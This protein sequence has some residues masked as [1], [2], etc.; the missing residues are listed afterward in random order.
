MKIL[1]FIHKKK[2]FLRFSFIGITGLLVEI[3]CVFVFYKHLGFSALKSKLFAFPIAVL[4]TWILNRNLT[5]KARKNGG[6]LAEFFRYLSVTTTGALVNN[7]VYIF[8]VQTFDEN[9]SIL[10]LAVAVGSVAGL[11]VNF[12]GANRYVFYKRPSR[13]DL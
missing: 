2:R 5:F 12:F 10:I 8:I 1:D 3:L 11:G 13:G 4:V 9:L 6:L 7:F